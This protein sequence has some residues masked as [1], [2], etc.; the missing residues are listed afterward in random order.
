MRGRPSQRL[1]E[2]AVLTLLAAMTDDLSRHQLSRLRQLAALIDADG[3]IPLDRA[4]EVATPGGDDQRRQAAFRQFRRAVAEAAENAGVQLTLVADALKTAPAHRYCWFEGEDPVLAD[5]AAMSAHESVR[6]RPLGSAA[7]V[8]PRA[9]EVHPVPPVRIHVSAASAAA[10]PERVGKVEEFVRL[11]RRSLPRW[12]ERPVEVTYEGETTLGLDVSAERDRLLAQAD[13]V[14]ALLT[15]AYLSERAGELARH[16][17]QPLLVAFAHLNGTEAGGPG[18]RADRIM[19]RGRPFTTCRGVDGR[20]QFVAEV[21]NELRRRLDVRS[22][23]APPPHPLGDARLDDGRDAGLERLSRASVASRR[24]GGVMVDPRA[25]ETA[26][27]AAAAGLG[28]PGRSA[29][30]HGE[31]VLAVDRLAEWARRPEP[32]APRLCALLGDVGMGKTTTTKLLTER[33]LDLRS[34]DPTGPLPLLFDLRDVSVDALPAQPT[35][36]GVVDALLAGIEDPGQR[37]SAEDVLAAVAAGNCLVIFDGLDEVLVHL[38]PHQGQLFV[39]ALWHATELAPSPRRSRGTGRGAPGSAGTGAPDAGCAG[40]P[41]RL[42]LTCRTHY[43]RSVREE[44]GQ[45]TGQDR[46][47]PRGRD[48]LALLMLPFSEQQVRAYLAANVPGADADALLELMDSVHNLRELAERPLTLS[49]VT[50]QLELIERAKLD[51][52]TLRPADLYAAMVDR[53]LARD[54]GKHI[55]LPEHKLLIMESLAAQLWR[56]RRASWTVVD[57]EQWL[58][59]FL[60]SRPDLQRHY[61]QRRPD[62]WKEDLRTATFLIRRGEDEFA[63]AHTSLQE[64]FLSRY[65]L[66][67]LTLG[68]DQVD[69]AAQRW[70]LAVPSPETLDFLGQG[71]A[72]LD[73]DTRHACLR[74]LAALAAA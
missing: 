40:R 1:P 71:L 44:V 51:G 19:M 52:R 42:L 29:R 16:G 32:S 15:P 56:A 64:Y 8:P 22:T 58:L 73:A 41:S 45:F 4:L 68:A 12:E 23:A 72:A 53:W 25:S 59:D 5:L 48:Y 24:P 34:R 20:E 47:G 30:S 60:D 14:V 17:T 28:A 69:T 55:L 9:A 66:R 65:L 63:F 62:L 38:S 57:L 10:D 27:D 26:F 3:G 49:F 33:L 46:D 31:P 13:L 7:E 54:D 39:R 74:T 70:E 11:L 35:L 61:G 6:G 36:K 2:R 67:A 18:L 43:F 50:E 21:A 37:Y